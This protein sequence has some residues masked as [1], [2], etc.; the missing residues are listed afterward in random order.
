MRS[1]STRKHHPSIGP[2]RSFLSDNSRRD[3]II[4][5]LVRH[6][7]LND[8]DSLARTSLLIHDGLLGYRS[9]LLKSTLHCVNNDEPVDPEST[10]RFRARAGN[11]YFDWEPSVLRSS[12][13]YLPYNGKSGECARD[14]VSDCRRCGVA[15]CRVRLPSAIHGGTVI[16][17]VDCG[18]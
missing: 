17:T 3:S 2:P 5:S 10:L 13:S 18:S 11:H 6:I 1:P 7:D 15:V 12:H 8:L 14:L 4:E 9:S 16:M